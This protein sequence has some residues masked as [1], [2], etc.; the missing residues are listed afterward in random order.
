MSSGPHPPNTDPPEGPP[1]D[2]TGLPGLRTWPGVYLF[3]FAVF[4]AYVILLAALTR[5][6]A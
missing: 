3:V 5:G 1:D 4:V 2:E 6:F